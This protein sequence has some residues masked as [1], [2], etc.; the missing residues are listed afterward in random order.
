MRDA[1]IDRLSKLIS[2]AP[3]RS[4][5][6][7][8]GDDNSRPRKIP[9][10][11]HISLAE[12]WFSLVLLAIVVYSTI[13]CVQAVGWVDHLNILTLTTA[14]GLIVGVVAAKQ[15]R[16]PLL[17]TH[18][19]ALGLG[20][21][22]AFWQTSGA[23]YG[24]NTGAFI[25]GIH[26][27]VTILFSNGSSDD[28]SIFLF[29]IVSLSFVLAYTSA[30]L[31]YR[32]RN[33]WLMIVANAI[34]MLINLSNVDAGYIIFLTVFLV[35]GLLL[36]LRFNLYESVKRWKRQGLRYADDIGWDVMQAGALI[37]IGILVFSWFLP[38]GYKNPTASQIW[39]ASS[40]PWVQLQNTWDRVVSINGGA[41]VS[42]HGN[43][44][45]NLVLAGNPN[46][47][48][49]VVLTVQ[50]DDDGAQYLMSLNYDTY[51]GTGGWTNGP[52][53]TTPV[54][55]N[56]PYSYGSVLTHTM[57]QR[58]NIVNPPG[59]Q[60]S[61]VLGASA[62]ATLDA[63]SVVQAGSNSGDVISWQGQG[64]NLTPGSH[65][66]VTSYVSS[67]DEQSL[68]SIPM[69]ADSPH[70]PPDYDGP[71]PPTVYSSQALVDAYVQLPANL[72]PA[73][74]NLA[75]KIVT[76]A[77]A[78]TVYDKVV[79]LE[80]YLRMHYT[81]SVDVNKPINEEGVSWFLFRSG[82]KGFCNY[83]SSAMTLMARSLG[84]P[85]REAVG[86]TNGTN[87]AKNH[88]H[89][90][91]G[92]D[93]HSW[94]QVYFA[95]YG[96]INFEPSASFA[97]FTRP[98]PN[99]FGTGN[100]NSST[101][102]LSGSVVPP[103]VKKHLSKDDSSDSSGA[104]AT[105]VAQSQL[106]LRQQIGF[107]FGGL[108]LLALLALLLFSVWWSRL[109][110]R[111]TLAPRLYGR[112]CVLANWAGIG[113]RPSQ[114][115][116]EYMNTLALATPESAPVLERFSNI[117]VRERWADPESEEHPRRSGEME[118][119]PQLWKRLQPRLFLYV[120]RHPYFLRW[121]PLRLWDFVMTQWKRQRARR[122][123]RDEL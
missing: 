96:W 12:G 5:S 4:D 37:S 110:R 97:T 58:I 94:T 14:L 27:W 53:D 54:K 38:W 43:F 80:S 88:R 89:V 67:A 86:Y 21:L 39:D 90:I 92:T 114:T 98:L 35:A 34:V 83:F 16:F 6:S 78:T 105:N 44:R 100:G 95:G 24:G 57:T 76:D 26:H 59:E 19:V 8:K 33:P 32:L 7:D 52:T 18:V 99:Q 55:T 23:F 75:V 66:T 122:R 25:Q 3:R 117:Y 120:L 64:W 46:L 15:R 84:I 40:N 56:Q 87:D 79:A 11:L 123:L 36:V 108:V 61:Y 30:W 93:A 45:D 31:V 91:Y 113:L 109:F 119:L 71:L 112:L 48:H 74:H 20:L 1:T 70:Y 81:Y 111:Y 101:G 50:T 62:I 115:P 116:Y 17:L 13:W 2:D 63:S 107:A 65:Y 82:N 121:L 47:N 41:N 60:K 51:F 102:N 106:Q 9:F 10:E 42:N 85:A 104:S 73:I 103:N 49:D 69:P 72:D 22:L 28:D 29:F 68:R 77:K 118:E